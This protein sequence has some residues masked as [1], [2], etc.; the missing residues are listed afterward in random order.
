MFVELVA[1]VTDADLKLDRC[2]NLADHC[3]VQERRVQ[4]ELPTS[5]KV[6]TI[7]QLNH[8]KSILSNCFKHRLTLQSARAL[9]FSDTRL[10]SKYVNTPI[11]MSHLLKSCT[12]IFI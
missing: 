2:V 4:A 8:F 12:F 6:L 3:S 9:K 7:N 11:F 1:I 10:L 5:Q